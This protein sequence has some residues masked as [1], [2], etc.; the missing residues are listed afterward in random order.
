MRSLLQARAYS[1]A[2][3]GGNDS[4]TGGCIVSFLILV[5]IATGVWAWVDPIGFADNSGL[6]THSSA[7]AKLAKQ[8]QGIQDIQ[9]VVSVE[10]DGQAKDVVY[11]FK[12][13]PAPGETVSAEAR[14]SSATFVHCKDGWQYYEAPIDPPDNINLTQEHFTFRGQDGRS[15]TVCSG[16]PVWIH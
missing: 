8:F 2:A 7:K 15:W 13:H 3:A 4:F 1:A 5:A 14:R 10:D 12:V 6:L 11:E 16:R 9:D